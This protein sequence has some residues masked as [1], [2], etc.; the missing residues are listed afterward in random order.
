MSAQGGAVTV[1][2]PAGELTMV[3]A[4]LMPKWTAFA[5]PLFVTLPADPAQID[6]WCRAIAA[7]ASV[8]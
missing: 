8:Q 6:A 4:P 7:D 5:S 3:S 2:A 1:F